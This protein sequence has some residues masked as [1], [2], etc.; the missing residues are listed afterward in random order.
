MPVISKTPSLAFSLA[1][2]LQPCT[3]RTA[4]AVCP[5]SVVE[6]TRDTRAGSSR[7]LWTKISVRSFS[8]QSPPGAVCDDDMRR[9]LFLRRGLPL[10]LHRRRRV[11]LAHAVAVVRGDTG[12][13]GNSSLFVVRSSNL[14]SYIRYGFFATEGLA[15]PGAPDT[16]RAWWSCPRTSPATARTPCARRCRSSGATRDARGTP[17]CSWCDRRTWPR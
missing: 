1:F 16:P 14:A 7:P 15:K 11:R 17:L 10:E 5:C 8:T 2:R 9:I 6:K 4:T 3:M 13:A 12:C